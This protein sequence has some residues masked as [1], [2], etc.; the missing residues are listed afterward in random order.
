MQYNPTH[1]PKEC[2]DMNDI[3]AEIDHIDNL[4]ITLLSTRFE[5]VKEASKFKKNATE[6]QAK[7][8][9]NSML[10]QRKQWADAQGLD[11]EVIKNFYSDLVKY[12]IAEELKQFNNK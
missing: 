7:E 6:V 2:N 4:I 10:E 1:S 5:Y 12:F 11:G 3:R 8:R 9:F